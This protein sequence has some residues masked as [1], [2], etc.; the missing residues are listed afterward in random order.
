MTVK[1]IASSQVPAPRRVYD[2]AFSLL[3]NRRMF[4][5]DGRWEIKRKVAKQR[6]SVHSMWRPLFFW[7]AP[8][9]GELEN[10]ILSGWFDSAMKNVR[11]GDDKSR[12]WGERTGRQGMSFVMSAIWLHPT[13]FY[14]PFPPICLL[15]HRSTPS[16]APT[17]TTLLNFLLRCLPVSSFLLLFIVMIYLNT[18]SSFFIPPLLHSRRARLASRNDSSFPPACINNTTAL[19]TL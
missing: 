14:P 16:P 5:R 6:K 1:Q 12:C 10:I 19:P 15:L 9:L 13:S 17:H 11:S 8:R 4:M 7:R 18:S 2:A 3:R